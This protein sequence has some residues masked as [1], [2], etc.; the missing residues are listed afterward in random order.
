MLHVEWYHI[1]WPRLTAKRVEPV[2]SISWASCLSRYA[3]PWKLKFRIN[4]RSRACEP[5][6]DGCQSS[7]PR[8]PG[9]LTPTEAGR[10]YERRSWHWVDDC[11][12]VG[13]RGS[14]WSSQIL[15]GSYVSDG[16]V[17]DRVCVQPDHQL[18]RWWTVIET[19]RLTARSAWCFD[20]PQ[21]ETGLDLFNFS[22]AQNSSFP[23]IFSTIVR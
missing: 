8:P 19:A 21:T 13:C 4:Q 1:C 17:G 20:S 12:R 5:R 23:Q 6:M 11:S 2:V 22:L 3:Q 7:S 18:H 10:V 9:E 16:S 14:N 15:D